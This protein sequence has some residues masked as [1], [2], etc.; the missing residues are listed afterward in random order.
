MERLKNRRTRLGA[1]GN[2]TPVVAEGYRRVVRAAAENAP[3]PLVRVRCS[4]V[5]GVIAEINSH[6][7]SEELYAPPLTASLRCRR[8]L[9]EAE[10]RIDMPTRGTLL[11]DGDPWPADVLIFGHILHDRGQLWRRATSHARL[12]RMT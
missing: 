4:D 12:R 1:T 9:G 2:R 10:A 11:A 6:E 5:S 3:E 8:R 7:R